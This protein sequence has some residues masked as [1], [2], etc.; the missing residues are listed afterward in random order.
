MPRVPNIKAA[1]KWTRQSEKR[2]KR[3]LD[4]KTRLKT[5]FKKAKAS[6]DPATVSTVESQ[7]DKAAQKGIIHPNKAARKKSRLAKAARAASSAKPAALKAP[8]KAKAAKP[9]A[10]KKAAAK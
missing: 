7:F 4:T 5:I 6:G 8:A 1:V 10:R 3:N 9:A 2:R